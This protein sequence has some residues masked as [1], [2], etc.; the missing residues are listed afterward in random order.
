[1]QTMPLRGAGNTHQPRIPVVS[2]V[3]GIRQ[4][5]ESRENKISGTLRLWKAKALTE[6]LSG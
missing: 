3:E 2:T 4:V 1:M 5:R 6:G